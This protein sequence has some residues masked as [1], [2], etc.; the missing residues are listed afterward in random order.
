MCSS[1]LGTGGGCSRSKME[2]PEELGLVECGWE[3]QPE[4]A[5]SPQNEGLL[6]WVPE[7]EGPEAGRL[8]KLG[9]RIRAGSRSEERRV[10]KECRSRWAPY[11]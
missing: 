8:L 10:G 1:D 9:S 2:N 11:H 7:G 5:E 6:D 3:L 4:G